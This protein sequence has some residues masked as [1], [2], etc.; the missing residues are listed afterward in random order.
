MY[1]PTAR[2][3]LR[4]QVQK[5]LIAV[6]FCIAR[7]RCCA[8]KAGEYSFFSAI[9]VRLAILAIEELPVTRC[10][11]LKLRPRKLGRCFRTSLRLYQA[12]VLCKAG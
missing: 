12:T 2:T 6:A 1:S 7:V 5:A 3:A 11:L 8:T 10:T 4:T 9:T